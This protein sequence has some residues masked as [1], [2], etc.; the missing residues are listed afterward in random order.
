MQLSRILFRNPGTKLLAL[1]IACATWFVLSGQRRERISE[2]SYRIPLSVVNVPSG[3]MIVSP[4]PDAV[5]V[6][7]RGAFTP[8]RSSSPD[9]LEAVID[10]AD[11]VPGEKRYRLGARGHQRAAGGRGHRDRPGR[12]P[13]RPRRRRRE[14]APDRRRDHRRARAGRAR[15]R[16]RRR[17]ARARVSSGPARTLA[18]MRHAADRARSRSRAATRRFSDDDDPRARRRPGVRVREGQVVT[19]RVR[20]RPAAAARADAPADAGPRQKGKDVKLFG[21]DGLRGKAG[22]F[23]LDPASVR[24]LGRELGT[25]PRPAA[26]RARVVVGGDTRESTPRIV[27][28]LAAGL[29]EGGCGVA[30]GRASSR[31]RA[32][33]SSS[34]SSARRPASRSPPRTIPTR[35]TA[36]RS[37]APTAAS[38]PTRRRSTS[39]ASCSTARPAGERDADAGAAR[40]GSRASRD[41]RLAAEGAAC[42]RDLDGFPVLL[43]AGNGAAFQIG[44]ARVPA[45]GRARDG[46]PRRARRPQH[47]PRRAA[48]SIPRGWRARRASRGAALGV[49]FDGDADRSIFAD[50]TGRILDGDDVLWIVAR[51]WKAPRPADAGRRRRDRHVQLRARG[52]ARARGHRVPPRPRSATATWRG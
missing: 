48:R 38:G 25:T 46:D 10:L 36:S 13:H 9:K 32:S 47:Q 22:E 21:T 34:S 3:T 49:A 4:L 15:R 1:A 50:E 39:R 14:D 52:G 41:L 45:R 28:D 18:R 44:P 12:D 8:L 30:A 24:L 42:P 33:P 11:T 5:D 2:R 6:R 16:G 27:A 20:I 7:M 43:D 17:A 26:G 29:A 40:P 19:V 35:T 37:S 23:P 51:D 31:R